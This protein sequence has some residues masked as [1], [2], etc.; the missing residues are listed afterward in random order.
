MAVTVTTALGSPERP[1]DGSSLA[2]KVAELAGDRLDGALDD[3][4]RPAADLLAALA[5]D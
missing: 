1:L 3:P 2:A 5:L 4:A